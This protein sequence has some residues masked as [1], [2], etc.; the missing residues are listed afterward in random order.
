MAPYPTR[1]FSGDYCGT[2]SAMSPPGSHPKTPPS[3]T[4][5]AIRL[6]VHFIVVCGVRR[7]LF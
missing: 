2:P 1:E 6:N 7:V 4:S 3:V 5:F